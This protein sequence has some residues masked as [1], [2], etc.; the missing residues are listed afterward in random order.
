MTISMNRWSVIILTSAMLATS[1]PAAEL[2]KGFKLLI[3]HGFQ[4]QGMITKDDGFHL[5]TYFAANYTTLDWLGESNPAVYGKPAG[6]PW[7]RWASDPDHMPP[8][9]DEK[10]FMGK[11]ISVSLGDEPD[12]NNPNQR[13]K[14]IDWYHKFRDKFPR[15]ILYTN[16]WGL[17][18]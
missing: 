12:L 14:H 4:I 11:L 7:G 10:R 1:A 8:I 2:S 9:G 16:N 17:Q 6:L 13:Q 3:E 18:I 5:P 15:T